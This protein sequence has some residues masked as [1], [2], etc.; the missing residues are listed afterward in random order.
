M[1][2]LVAPGVPV[3]GRDHRPLCAVPE[4]VVLTAFDMVA[5]EMRVSVG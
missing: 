3:P 1:V 4:D 2:L 5:A